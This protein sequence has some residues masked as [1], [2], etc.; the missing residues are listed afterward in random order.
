MDALVWLFRSS[1]GSRIE[2]KQALI[3]EIEA[4]LSKLAERI[5]SLQLF[6]NNASRAQKSSL[7]Q[8]CRI[9]THTRLHA[10]VGLVPRIVT[11]YPEAL[12]RVLVDV[13]KRAVLGSAP[14]WL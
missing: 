3:P 9:P 5:P 14:G 4:C 8:G 2:D 10:Q 11:G 7:L 12:T 6:V 1:Q 13:I